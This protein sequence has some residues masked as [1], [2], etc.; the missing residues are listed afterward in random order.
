MEKSKRFKK[1]LLYIYAVKLE[2]VKDDIMR[3]IEKNDAFYG[4]FDLDD[5]L[6][7]VLDG[8]DHDF[9]DENEEDNGPSDYG[10]LNPDLLDLNSN[11]Q[12]DPS[13]PSTMSVASRF[14]ERI[15]TSSSIL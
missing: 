8:V 4:K 3:N 15:I 2:F 7:E 12:D 5:L 9:L 14:V 13:Q 6:D 10:M 11:E 1:R